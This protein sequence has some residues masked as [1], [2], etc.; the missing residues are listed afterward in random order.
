MS[1]IIVIKTSLITLIKLIKYLILLI[2]LKLV[3]LYKY[4]L[5]YF[6]YYY[7]KYIKSFL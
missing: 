7:N 6:I 4:N 1:F 5:N 3:Y 2:K